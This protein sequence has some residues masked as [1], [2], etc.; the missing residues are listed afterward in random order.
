MFMTISKNKRNGFTL[1]EILVV[2]AIIGILASIV[3]F[4][5]SDARQQSLIGRAESELK[6][7]ESALL[8]Y[9]QREGQLPNGT[10]ICSL[11]GFRAG[12]TVAQQDDWTIVEAELEARTSASLPSRDPWG[13]FYAYDNN[14]RVTIEALPTIICSLGPDGQLQTWITDVD[15]ATQRNAQG[16]DICIFMREPDD[17]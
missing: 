3:L 8:L 11:C 10:N 12:G 4:N 13:R 7:I 6:S 14:Y 5:V 16:D 2:V 17:S 1:I 9:R 15:A